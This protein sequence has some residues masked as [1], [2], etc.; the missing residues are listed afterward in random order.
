MDVSLH[1]VRVVSEVL[2]HRDESQAAYDRWPEQHQFWAF[3]DLDSSANAR[4]AH[5]PRH[6]YVRSEMFF[7]VIRSV[8]G[9]TVDVHVVKEI[10]DAVLLRGEHFRTLLESVLLADDVARRLAEDTADAPFPFGL[11]AA[12][13]FGHAKRMPRPT[14]DYLGSAIDLLARAVSAATQDDNMLLSQQAYDAAHDILAEY[15][16]VSVEAPRALPASQSKA[17]LSPVYVRSL[18]VDRLGLRA[19]RG[20]FL[21]WAALSG[22]APASG[23]E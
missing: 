15:P 8:V 9:A 21:P 17:A 5:G 3:V 4:I 19:H 7:A 10:G 13:G 12:L 11:K 6:G 2:R 16:F 22:A 20:H 23:P 14:D 18:R 1:A